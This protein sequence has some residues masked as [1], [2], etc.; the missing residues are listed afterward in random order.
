MHL[1]FDVAVLGGGP[2]GSALAILMARQG[3]RVAV[4]EKSDFATFRP[5]EHLP[6]DAT[7]ALAALGCGA[8]L[9]ASVLIKSPGIL[10]D[11]GTDIP[12]Y[13]PYA[14]GEEGLG[15][16][17]DRVAFDRAL[18]A[19]AG[20]C[21]VTLVERASLV[22]AVREGARW[23]VNLETPAGPLGLTAAL[24]VD[25]T[26]RSAAFARRQDAKPQAHG[27]LTAVAALV[28]HHAGMPEDRRLLVAASELG[29]WSATPTPSGDIVATFYSRNRLRDGLSA[30]RWWAR[31]F[32]SA[33]I[34]RQ[35]LGG[36]ATPERCSTFAAFPRMVRPMYGLGWVAIGDAATC[37]DPLSGHG[38]LYAFESAFRAAEM[39]AA[40]PTIAR[41]GRIYEEA[42]AD[43]FARHLALREAAYAHA[44]DRFPAA[45]F[46]RD[47]CGP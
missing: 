40:D 45:P 23:A 3:A 2:A 46:W 33:P 18:F 31:G 35:R 14:G 25:A 39:V 7:G 44:A 28:P 10:S 24:V 6:P 11:W 20:E 13:K 37:H 47:P 38:V 36:A 5:G 9:F 15:L 29:W 21:G 34:V 4:V 1:D 41:F 26:G 32:Q 17:L 30:A 43:R 19:L 22:A 27:D 16:N 12:L 42:M 8:K